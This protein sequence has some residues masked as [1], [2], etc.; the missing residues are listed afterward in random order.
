[1]MRNSF[2]LAVLFAVF[3]TATPIF[4]RDVSLRI[5]PESPCVGM[6]TNLIVSS[7]DAYPEFDSIPNI[8]GIR[9]SGSLAR[10]SRTQIVNGRRT[11][12]FD[13]VLSFTAEKPGSFLLP[14]FP[15]VV[16]GKTIQTKPLNFSVSPAP[17]PTQ[18]KTDSSVPAF[19]EVRINPSGKT[20]YVGEEISVSVSYFS[21]AP[22]RLQPTEYPVLTNPDGAS[23]RFHD[24]RKV[25]PENPNFAPPSQH[26]TR[27]G[28]DRFQVTEFTTK[29]RPIASGRLAV[30][31]EGE[32]AL[33]EGDGFFGPRTVG[34]M[35]LSDTTE[36]IEVKPLP[37]P[38]TG[39]G[40]APFCGLVGPWTGHVEI[41]P[42]PYRVGEPLTLRIDFVG[43]GSTEPL[44]PL[45][46]E[47][48]GFRAYPPEI[49]QLPSGAQLRYTLIPLEPGE[50]TLHFDCAFFDTTSASY[51]RV[52]FQKVLNFEKARTLVGA[53]ETRV[54]DASD[55]ETAHPAS[56]V[57]KDILYLHRLSSVNLL[58]PL[59]MNALLP[60]GLLLGIGLAVL[61]AALWISVR[62][63]AM[64]KD[65][66]IRR[67][68][69]AAK[70][71]GS[72]LRVLGGIPPEELPD[73]AS[74]IAALLNDWLGLPAGT[75]LGETA[76]KIKEAS[77]EFGSQLAFLSDCEWNPHL[78]KELNADF[79]RKL[80]RTLRAFFLLLLMFLA[81]VPALQT[82]MIHAQDSFLN[83]NAKDEAQ[84]TAFAVR[85]N[86]QNSALAEDD[87]N[88][89][90]TPQTEE[91]AMTCYD[92]G[93]FK[94]AMRFYASLLEKGRIS[95]DL[96]YNLGNCFYQ[97]GDYARALV[98][99]E[100]AHILAPRNADT[101]GN[102]NLT[103]AKLMLPDE[104]RVESPRH[105]LAFLRDSLR[106]DEWMIFTAFSVMVILLALAM[107]LLRRKQ[108]AFWTLIAGCV[109]LAI[110]LGFLAAKALAFDKRKIAV[111]VEPDAKLFSL[112][113]EQSGRVEASLKTG[114]ILH[115]HE[116]RLNWR[117]ATLENGTSGWIR[118]ADAVP[119]WS[120][121]PADAA[122]GASRT[123]P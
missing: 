123:A 36:P 66:A 33:L 86:E 70:A 25:N 31:A 88:N 30:R 39:P 72:L 54:I 115:L 5:S 69:F 105:A 23:F 1:M 38:P 85:E 44:I 7:P 117:R 77:P 119:L 64:E 40:A 80:L 90:L 14:S 62:R 42:G 15:V 12:S 46:F 102:L 114:E 108:S 83:D 10:S 103:R 32:V 101:L 59:P 110:S 98:C 29:I 99:Y 65:P 3:L 24:F 71:K 100:R 60:G 94:A 43:A 37:E 93:D 92:A 121:D 18:A 112:P 2:L 56:P 11:S 35:R 75:P 17:T 8:D 26:W 41:S 111:V 21:R 97:T 81:P 106:I 20:L 52:D 49:Q 87:G 55:N 50:Q 57:R 73:K 34:R 84:T 58:A 78:R 68:M 113:S 95:A 19:A 104:N 89:R 82:N 61:L 63:R 4:A 74:E 76:K 6:E 91:E 109:L 45:K 122:N 27:I 9:W 67:R 53:T 120:D 96:F 116:S 79:Q 47:P 51:R 16:D 48:H 28:V 22:L 118:S 13:C 107:R